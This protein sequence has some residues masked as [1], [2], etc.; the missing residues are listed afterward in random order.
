M[1]HLETFLRGMETCSGGSTPL[2]GP[3]LKP[4]LEGWKH[5][6][7]QG[8]LPLADVLETFLRG[9]ETALPKTRASP[10]TPLKPSLE[11][12]KLNIVRQIHLK[13]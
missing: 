5:A 6:V 13:T 4:S 1:N 9:M 10:Q 2:S 3:P 8:A 7:E 12:W 11:G